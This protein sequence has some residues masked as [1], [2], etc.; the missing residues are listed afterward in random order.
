ME[1]IEHM[2][3]SAANAVWPGRESKDQ[4]NATN[5]SN[6]FDN[7]NN[8][9]RSSTNPKEEPLSGV[10]GDTARGE[11][12]D[13]GNLGEQQAA[14]VQAKSGSNVNTAADSTYGTNPPGGPGGGG[15]NAA[16]VRG[17]KVSSA[18]GEPSSDVHSPDP[19]PVDQVAREHGGE[20]GKAPSGKGSLGGDD[21]RGASGSDIAGGASLGGGAGS[22]SNRSSE[23]PLGGQNSSEK[24]A[25]TTKSAGGGGG[26]GSVDSTGGSGSNLNVGS[27]SDDAGPADGGL[28]GGGSGASGGGLGA[29]GGGGDDQPQKESQGEGTGEKYVRSTG[30]RADGGDFDAANP[31]AGR[32]ADRLLEEKGIGRE[33][34]SDGGGGGM[35]HTDDNAGGHNGDH[36][37][38][39]TG[40]RTGNNAGNHEN[41]SH[42]GKK[43]LGEKLKSKIHHKPTT[44]S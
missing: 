10:T 25:R 43:S 6:N 14:N 8:N 33:T 20:A 5:R 1:T 36:T 37:G 22:S 3:T 17:F 9:T 29:G 16:A 18:G 27:G 30:L 15:V 4:P 26:L 21:A 32:E 35:T 12:Y 34:V 13:A 38:D 39:R 7:N 44:S 40:D 41:E 31:G 19:R 42:A 23:Y 28:G 11:P 2:A 24:A